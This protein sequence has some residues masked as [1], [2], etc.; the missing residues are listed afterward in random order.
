MELL[1]QVKLWG[2][3]HH[4]KWLDYFRIVLGMILIWKGVSFALNLSAFTALMTQSRLV[5]AV[6]L[7]IVAHIIIVLHVIGGLFIVLGSHTRTSCLLNLPVLL[8]AV[9]FVNL[10]HNIFKPY[11]EF[12]LSCTVLV[13][14]IC[15]LIEGDGIISVEHTKEG[16]Q[17]V[18]HSR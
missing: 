2:D 18:A 11:A 16:D 8:V 1:S 15:F 13:G 14:L 6:S 3:R 17:S 12:W 4:P 10:S 7:S 5:T 9:F